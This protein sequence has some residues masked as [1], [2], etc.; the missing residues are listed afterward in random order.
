MR[1]YQLLIESKVG[2]NLQHLEDLV[3]VDGSAGALQALSV[4]ERL[5]KNVSDV[6]IKWDGTPAVIFGRDEAGMFILTDVAG[7]S[8]KNYNGRVTTAADLEG[9]ILN[10]GN[11]EV[12]D[13]R[14]NFAASMKA[15]WPAF[16]SAT[17]GNFRGFIHGDLLYNKMP[18]MKNGHYEFTPNKVTYSVAANSEI[19]KRIARSQVGVVI[20][21]HT[22]L[23]GTVAPADINTL[24]EGN[25]FIMPPVVMQQTPKIDT[26][27]I[28]TLRAQVQKNAT[29]IDQLVEP[30]AGLSDIR[31]II[32]TYVNQT[33]KAR[34]WDKLTTG[35]GDWIKNSN[36]SPNK[37]SR[38]LDSEHFDQYPVLFA[39][40][41]Q[42]QQLKNQVI[43][44]F[45]SAE[46]DVKATTDG[47]RGGE[48]YVAAQDKVKLVP[49]HK[50]TIG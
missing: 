28:N 3:F 20:H 40:V 32:Y 35:F 39:L 4:L 34:Q 7:F 6:S 22:D 36:I 18:P 37:Q 19:G 27:S 24:K 29:L 26:K 46:V 38:I 44:D 48:G 15:A 2:R 25:L 5:A 31:N 17:P 12:D 42:I 9:M 16:E 14:R 8:A 45:D 23:D 10:R 43:D 49:R 11:R 50:W 47:A 33:S 41:L 13:A 1:Y 21:T 30:Q